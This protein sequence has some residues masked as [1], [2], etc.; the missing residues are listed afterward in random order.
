MGKWSVGSEQP[1]GFAKC[2]ILC[3]REDAMLAR[4]VEHQ[5]LTQLQR[6][7]QPGHFVYTK[8]VSKNTNGLFKQLHMYPVKKLE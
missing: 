6:R 7:T 4:W 3:S 2:C 5:A 8:N 1:K